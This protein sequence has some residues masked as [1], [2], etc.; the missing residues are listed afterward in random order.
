MER[1]ANSRRPGRRFTATLAEMLGLAL[2]AI[3]AVSCA[4]LDWA[5]QSYESG[6]TDGRRPVEPGRDV[7][8]LKNADLFAAILDASQPDLRSAVNAARKDG[9]SRGVQA[10][11]AHHRRLPRRPYLRESQ[12]GN[13]LAAMETSA[14]N[15][16]A[17]GYHVRDYDYFP[18]K[19]P[20][21]WAADPHKDRSWSAWLHAWGFLDP[22]MITWKRTGNPRYVDFA[23]RIALDWIKQNLHN[24]RPPNETWNDMAE[25][26]R[27]AILAALVDDALRDPDVP[28]KDLLSLLEA[29]YAHAVKL[30]DPKNLTTPGNLGLFQMGGLLALSE[31]IPELRNSKAH[32]DY[33]IRT[34]RR[35]FA[36]DFSAEGIQLEHSPSYNVFL[37]NHLGLLLETGWLGNDTRLKT[38]FAKA[39]RNVIWLMHPDGI[40]ARV[41]DSDP[42]EVKRNLLFTDDLYVRYAL[43]EGQKGRKPAADYQDFHKTGYAVFRSPWDFRPWKNASYLFFTAAFHSIV[44]KHADDFSFEW[45]DLGQRLIIDSGRFAYWYSDR[46]RIYVESTA[47]HNTVEIDGKDYSRDKRDAFGAAVTAA[48]EAGGMYF[49]EADLYRKAFRT[50]HR[51]VLVF[52]PGRWV[53][54]IDSLRSPDKHKYTQWFHLNPNLVSK[55]KGGNY[56]ATIPRAGKALRIVSLS[57]GKTMRSRR[58]R[59]KKTPR[60]QGWTSPA[61]NSLVRNDAI[62]FDQSASNATFVTLL[63]LGDA[64]TSV[65]PQRVRHDAKGDEWQVQWRA[66]GKTEGFRFEI[67]GN[68]RTLRRL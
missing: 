2:V 12:G 52:N 16:L 17:H 65:A 25:S 7:A 6:M 27:A 48:G 51:R 44:H 39:N 1:Q 38:L 57:P 19:S 33:A 5:V 46:R 41:G 32:S 56:V 4:E 62:G 8:G 55:G 35:T 40:V 23:R 54:V 42:M 60:L 29:S 66:G 43:T 18:L 63:W 9:L 36:E 14:K 64:K 26:T 53:V 22:V 59:G 37:V 11:R 68:K 45:S 49:V 3:L 28:D 31:T 20:V 50:D 34:I 10:L 24:S 61:Q 58:V 67:N 21:N 15:T 47:A 13:S 30:A